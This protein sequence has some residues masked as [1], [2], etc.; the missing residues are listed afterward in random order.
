MQ[1]EQRIKK[2]LEENPALEEG[3]EGEMEDT[4]DETFEEKEGEEISRDE[5]EFSFEDYLGEDDTPGYR[6][7]TSN[8]SLGQHMTLRAWDSVLIFHL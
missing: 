3:D 5:N 1:L 8:Y 4:A 7:N 6:L 2:E